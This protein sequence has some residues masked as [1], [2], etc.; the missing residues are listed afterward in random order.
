MTIIGLP[1]ETPD[2]AEEL[3]TF[4]RDYHDTITYQIAD[5]VVERNSPIYFTP[6]RF[7]ITIPE[8]E[9]ESFHHYIEFHRKDGY[10]DREARK[11]Y[12]DILVR[13][14]QEFRGARQLDLE[15]ER[16]SVGPDDSVF[17]MSLHAGALELRNY[18][19][20]W[21][22]LPFEGLVSIGYKLKQEFTDMST[23]GTLFELYDDTVRELHAAAV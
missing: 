6:D 12:R 5:F 19:V 20:K 21:N 22:N 4:L 11:V 10:D 13:T 9:R 15:E 14:L 16:S 18:Y 23:E 2:E 3:Y 17:C 1:S 7:G 8:A